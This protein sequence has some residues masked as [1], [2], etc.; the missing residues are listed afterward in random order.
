[1][2]SLFSAAFMAENSESYSYLRCVHS[3]V[4]AEQTF[5]WPTTQHTHASTN[6][7]SSSSSIRTRDCLSRWRTR[8]GPCRRTGTARDQSERETRKIGWWDGR[9][10]RRTSFLGTDKPHKGTIDRFG[11][12]R[13]RKLPLSAFFSSLAVNVVTSRKFALLLT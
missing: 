9:T 8:R 3:V 13:Q 7:I 6:L 10:D 12:K 1:M 2:L 4:L 11:P 5:A